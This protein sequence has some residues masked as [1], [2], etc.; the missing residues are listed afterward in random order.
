M[1]Y[2]ELVRRLRVEASVAGSIPASVAGQTGEIARLVGWVADA[3]REIQGNRLWKWQWEQ[4]TVTVNATTNVVTS[5]IPARRWVKDS[6][7]I[8]DKNLDFIEWGEFRLIY[9]VVSDGDITAW[10]IRPDNA[11][12]TN[13][14]PTTNTSISVERYAIPTELVN[15][16]DTPAM[17]SRWH[18]AIVW[19]A[20][21]KYAD[22]EEAGVL[23]ATAEAKLAPILA[24]IMDEGTEDYFL[25]AALA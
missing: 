20:L 22:C 14:K 6:A 21:M 18:M 19:K 17:P 7:F 24:E 10:S 8:T 9:P 5:S 16:G 4:A 2:L 12:V 1:N 15:D 3:W 25:G 23:R 13:Y 11:F